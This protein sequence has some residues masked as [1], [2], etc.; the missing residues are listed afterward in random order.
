MI[1]IPH[2]D[3][4]S[5]RVVLEGTNLSDTPWTDDEQI[6]V[7]QF[8]KIKQLQILLTNCQFTLQKVDRWFEDVEYRKHWTPTMDVKEQI[9]DIVN[10]K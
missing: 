7:S 10:L 5:V 9:D 8:N 6:M 2:P 3:G 1:F 4:E